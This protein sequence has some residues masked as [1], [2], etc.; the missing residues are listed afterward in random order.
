[1]GIPFVTFNAPGMWLNIQQSKIDDWKPYQL[2]SIKGTFKGSLL[3][4]QMASTGRNFRH[5]LDVVSTFGSHIA[6]WKYEL[7][8]IFLLVGRDRENR[9]KVL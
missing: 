7:T 2:E 5:L 8:S 6:I 1:M 4:K 3:A 9:S